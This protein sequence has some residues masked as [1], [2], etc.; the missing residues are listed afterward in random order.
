MGGTPR[1]I[2]PA[3]LFADGDFEVVDSS[4]RM[5]L[6]PVSL[7]EALAQAALEKALWWEGHILE[8]LRGLPPDA[9]VGTEPKSQYAL[10]R[11][12]TARERAGRRADRGRAPGE[13]EHGR[14]LPAPL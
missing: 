13:R 2:P 6:P 12:L 3:L 11:S 10:S 14:E 1:S 5:P 7:L 8:V 4:G 9:A